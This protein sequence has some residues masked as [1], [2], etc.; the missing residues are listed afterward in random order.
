MFRKRYYYL[1]ELQFLGF[2]YHGWQKQPDVITVEHMVLRTLFYVL[3]HK[4]CKVLAAGRTDAM[5]SASQTYIELFVDE[6]EIKVSDFLPLLNRN[7]PPDI[8]ALSVVEVDK[9]FAIMNAP[10]EK[11]YRYYFS[12]GSKNHPFA[13]PF[14][15]GII[16]Q[17]DI[18]SMQQASRLFEG[19]HDFKNYAYRPTPTTQTQGTIL[20]CV[21]IENKDFTASFFPK[22]SYFLQVVGRG[23]KR[24]QIRLM[25]GALFDVG[26]G[27][28][29]IE[30]IKKTLDSSESIKLERIAPASGLMV[31]EVRM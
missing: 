1:I 9:E 28:L 16:E 27:K 14:I 6:T 15:T 10:K 4:N 7:L 21:M 20:K 13:A 26:E 8:R 25:M 29:T 30:D 19:S 3:G 12:C 5:V 23:F 17:L 22:K 2:R 18:E 24:H 11:E 31:H